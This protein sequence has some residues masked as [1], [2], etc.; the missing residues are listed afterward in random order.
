MTHNDVLR[1]ERELGITVPGDY[2]ALVTDYPAELFQYAA[3]FD[4]MDDSERLIAMNRQVRSGPFYGA[5][6]PAHYFAI[7]EDGCGDYYCL[8]LTRSSSPVIFFDHE[9]RSFVE[10]AR[11]LQEWWPMV[12]REY[13]ES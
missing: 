6:W 13:E 2:Q 12:I 4:L 3:D 1:I 10:L 7:G 11:S 9:T 8:D 5:E